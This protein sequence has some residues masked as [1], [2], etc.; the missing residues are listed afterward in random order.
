MLS[1]ILNK[2][3]V[4]I[5]HAENKESEKEREREESC[6]NVQY[7]LKMKNKKKIVFVHN[8]NVFNNFLTLFVYICKICTY[9]YICATHVSIFYLSLAYF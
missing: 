4:I 7:K 6:T 3:I 9:M 5:K 2:I 8:K 1:K